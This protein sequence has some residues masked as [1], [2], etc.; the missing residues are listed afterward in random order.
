MRSVDEFEKL[1]TQAYATESQEDIK[2]LDEWVL[3]ETTYKLINFD[4]LDD[5]DEEENE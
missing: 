4:D 1:I 5:D 2:A 3:K